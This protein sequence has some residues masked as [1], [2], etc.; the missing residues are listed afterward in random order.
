MESRS[1]SRSTC[2]HFSLKLPPSSYMATAACTR[3]PDAARLPPPLPRRT[4]A[5][6]NAPQR[7]KPS[8][9]ESAAYVYD[10]QRRHIPDLITRRSRVQIPPPP[11]RRHVRG[12][13]RKPG[14]LSLCDAARCRR[15]LLTAR[16]EVAAGGRHVGSGRSTT[17]CERGSGSAARAEVRVRGCGVIQSGRVLRAR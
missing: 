10:R 17:L 3:E 13:L 14:G 2:K 12:P 4:S 11:P 1:A 16:C 8:R 6:V 15:S 9:M 5:H 7:T